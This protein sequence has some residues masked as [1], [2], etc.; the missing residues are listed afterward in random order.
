MKL[1]VHMLVLN[2]ASVIERALRSV[3]GAADEICIVDTGS[4]D[5]TPDLVRYLCQ[6]VGL[7]GT[8]TDRQGFVGVQNHPPPS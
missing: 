7:T 6:D 1:S 2:A 8:E 5:G 4:S 3:A